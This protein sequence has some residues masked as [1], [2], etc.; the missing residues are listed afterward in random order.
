MFVQILHYGSDENDKETLCTGEPIAPLIGGRPVA[1]CQA[2]L[3][4]SRGKLRRTDSKFNVENALKFL[5]FKSGGELT[6]T[7]D[8]FQKLPDDIYK[9]GLEHEMNEKDMT[10]T[11][12]LVPPNK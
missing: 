2:C 12:K 7:S 9:Y 11:F 1:P 5:L 8:E 10:M 3:L 4:I 6:I